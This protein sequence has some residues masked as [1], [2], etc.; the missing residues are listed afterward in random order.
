MHPLSAFNSR[1][2]MSS[3]DRY[4]APSR[5][6]NGTFLSRLIAAMA[7]NAMASPCVAGCLRPRAGFDRRRPPLSRP[8]PLPSWRRPCGD[9]CGPWALG[10]A[11]GT[12]Y[13]SKPRLKPKIFANAACR[14]PLDFRCVRKPVLR[15]PS[16]STSCTGREAN[17]VR[18]HVACPTSGCGLNPVGL[19][20]LTAKR[21][22]LLAQ[23]DGWGGIDEELHRG[24]PRARPRL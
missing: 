18:C 8:F 6:A 9:F 16:S 21:V 12:E 15:R 24:P 13:C 5:L 11:S 17:P 4:R 1:F 7:T 2:T 3:T 20:A 19:F 23:T 14:R 22:G 10:R